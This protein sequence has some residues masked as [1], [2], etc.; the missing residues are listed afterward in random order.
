MIG[1][2]AW[3]GDPKLVLQER[4]LTVKSMQ[5]NSNITC[6]DVDPAFIE[7]Y[8]E[9]NCKVTHERLGDQSV[10]QLGAQFFI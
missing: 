3:I 2:Q 7:K 1:P 4:K 5:R 6:L 8:D 10:H 9:A